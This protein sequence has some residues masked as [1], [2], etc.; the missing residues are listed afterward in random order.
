MLFLRTAVI[1]VNGDWL[2]TISNSYCLLWILIAAGQV[3]SFVY[4]ARV[5]RNKLHFLFL[6][7]C[8]YALFT[9]YTQ[10]PFPVERWKCFQQ[11]FEGIKEFVLFNPEFFCVIQTINQLK[12][13]KRFSA[14]F[15]IVTECEIFI[16]R[17]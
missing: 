7:G 2:A 3:S 15:L 11:G 12:Y 4:N 5:S 16:I 8:V 14:D 6:S 17:R 10:P 1:S 9:H 13:D